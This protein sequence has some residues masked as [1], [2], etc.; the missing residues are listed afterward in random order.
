[1]APSG[2][3]PYHGSCHW[4]TPTKRIDV[5][6]TLWAMM[7]VLGLGVHTPPPAYYGTFPSAFFRDFFATDVFDD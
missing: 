1:M 2:F 6:P 5:I 3:G 7:H 4:Y